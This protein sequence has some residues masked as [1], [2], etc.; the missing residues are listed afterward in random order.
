M[1]VTRIGDAETSG[2]VSGSAEAML[3]VVGWS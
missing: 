3:M 1:Y 2:T